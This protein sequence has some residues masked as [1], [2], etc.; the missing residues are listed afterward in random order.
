MRGRI[1]WSSPP[2][3]G[4]EVTVD[5]TLRGRSADEATTDE[6]TTD[7]ATTDE[8]PTDDATTDAAATRVVDEAV[9]Q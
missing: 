5:V 6:A 7:E 3:G 9:T 1:A 4:T 2:E 8:A